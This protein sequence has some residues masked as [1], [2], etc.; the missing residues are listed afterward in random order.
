MFKEPRYDYLAEIISF[1]SAA[2]AKDA[3]V[4]L[5][6][7]FRFAEGNEKKLRVKRAAIL[8]SNRAEAA[9]K[10]TGIKEETRKELMEI[11]KIYK[12]AYHRMRMKDESKN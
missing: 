3:V 6:E 4:L 8:A 12:E 9:A 10:R 7:E 2:Q 11:S 1:K 5:D